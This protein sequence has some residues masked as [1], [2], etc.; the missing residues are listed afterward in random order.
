M[1]EIRFVGEYEHSLDDKLRTILPAKFRRV[2][3]DKAYIHHPE[4]NSLLFLYPE[5]HVKEYLEN[6]P[7]SLD[8]NFNLGDLIDRLKNLKKVSIDR[9]GR[10]TIG[11]EFD[12]YF[13]D[14]ERVYFIGAGKYVLLYL[15]SREAYYNFKRERLNEG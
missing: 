15:G 13:E 5:N 14:G 1:A 3:G 7:S 4:E 9:I 6:L 10:M 8:R 11:K 12:D 2:F